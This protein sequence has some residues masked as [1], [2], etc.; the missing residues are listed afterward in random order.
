MSS[1]IL[2][3]LQRM[4]QVLTR[5]QHLGYSSTPKRG[6]VEAPVFCN[7]RDHALEEL[8]DPKQQRAEIDANSL[9]AKFISIKFELMVCHLSARYPLHITPSNTSNDTTVLLQPASF[10]VL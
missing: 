7:V 10:P 9:C 4:E 5:I 8:W 3:F 1:P 6:I 2:G